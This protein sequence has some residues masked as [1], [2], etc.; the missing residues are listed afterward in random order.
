M[1]IL[2][3]SV[4]PVDYNNQY[5]LYKKVCEGVLKKKKNRFEMSG[6]VLKGKTRFVLTHCFFVFP[7]SFERCASVKK[8]KHNNKNFCSYKVIVASVDNV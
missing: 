6:L 3:S 8:Q 7:F 5:G 4:C 2:A 1:Y